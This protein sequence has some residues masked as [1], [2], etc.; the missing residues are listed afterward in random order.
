MSPSKEE[1]SNLCLLLTLNKLTDHPDYKVSHRENM[2]RMFYG[3]FPIRCSHSKK[4]S[5]FYLRFSQNWN[6]IKARSSCFQQI[7]PL[8]KDLLTGGE[9]K[10]TV[11]GSILA[12][13][14]RLLQLII[15]G[16]EMGLFLY[17]IILVKE[18]C[19]RAVS[20]IASRK[21]LPLRIPI[22]SSLQT[23]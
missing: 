19:T 8:V 1:Y 3:K 2:G 21:Q 5:L 9:K 18:F 10:E 23:F 4:I 6:P 15:K 22:Q 14:D 7:L 16:L 20:I 12:A 17:F 13:N 11:T